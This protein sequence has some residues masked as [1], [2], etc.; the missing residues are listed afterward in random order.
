V[1]DVSANMVFSYEQD[2]K[3]LSVCQCDNSHH[4]LC[5]SGKST[6]HTHTHTHTESSIRVPKLSKKKSASN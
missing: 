5:I 1:L 3:V 6:T 4:I 2:S